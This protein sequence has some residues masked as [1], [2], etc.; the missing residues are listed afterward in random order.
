MASIVEVTSKQA[1]APHG[2]GPAAAKNPLMS[3]VAAVQE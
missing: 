1:S 3:P 2:R